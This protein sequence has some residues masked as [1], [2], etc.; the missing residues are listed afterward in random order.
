MTS[1]AIWDHLR[2]SRRGAACDPVRRLERF[3]FS[4]VGTNVCVTSSADIHGLNL[5]WRE[6]VS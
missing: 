1:F 2:R 3:T 5:M 4:T 6:G